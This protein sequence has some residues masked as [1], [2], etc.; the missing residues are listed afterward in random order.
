LIKISMGNNNWISVKERLPEHLDKV[1]VIFD[2]S[3]NILMASF[4]IRIGIGPEFL[5]YFADGRGPTDRIIT[6]WM[7]LPEPPK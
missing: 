5:P 1:L 3:D 7:S 2:G 6:H 4:Q